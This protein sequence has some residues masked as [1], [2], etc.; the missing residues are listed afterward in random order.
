[1]MK[2]L[3]LVAVSF[4]C[5]TLVSQTVFEKKIKWSEGVKEKA[6][7]VTFFPEFVGLYQG[8]MVTVASSSLGRV[9]VKE[10]EGESLA[11][12]QRVK[13]NLK[14]EKNKL[15]KSDQLIFGDDLLIISNYR[16][17]STSKKHF[18]IQKYL[19]KGE[20][21][22]PK[23]I[24]TVHW[25]NVPG[26]F[27]SKKNSGLKYE[28]FNAV[29][30]IVSEDKKSLVVMYPDDVN[31]S[32]K[33]PVHW[34]V[35]AYD[36]D[37]NED[38]KYDFNIENGNIYLDKV[39]LSNDGILYCAGVENTIA[40][41]YNYAYIHLQQGNILGESYHLLIADPH[42]K[43]TKLVD[44]GIKDSTIIAYS[45]GLS[46]KN[47][48]FYGL[49]G[50]GRNRSISDGMFIKKLNSEGEELFYTV[51]KF[52]DKLTS[53]NED[54]NPKTKGVGRGLERKN[55]TQRN[56]ILDDIRFT[57]SG[58]MVF[59]AEQFNLYF[60]EQYMAGTNGGASESVSI[61]NYVYGD[62]I[63]ISCA[64]TGEIKWMNRI[65]KYQHTT[66]DLGF[67]SSY[68]VRV[69]GQNVHLLMNDSEFYVNYSGLKDAEGSVKR[70]A[71]KNEVLSAV[72]INAA[73]DVDRVIHIQTEDKKNYYKCAPKTLNEIS[74]GVMLIAGMRV[75]KKGL[76]RTDNFQ[77]V[78]ELRLK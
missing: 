73:G 49:T 60:T 32:K 64:P 28:A 4:V 31:P 54:I 71:K 53:Y 16:N 18:F 1:M 11:S 70:K 7:K 27:A 48:V 14:Y 29:K 68:H 78:G 17:K 62:I 57:E 21:S 33:E 13:L 15:V 56:F 42:N 65:V 36:E 39:K 69:K 24:A 9:F 35:V 63:A 50:S 46:G 44:L 22:K 76:L 40:L 41:T 45:M 61:P 75:E 37:L 72:T 6:L 10:Y 58:D 66:S 26:V 3:I 34:N 77:V 59:L 38:W 25:E 19:G 47:P 51:Q 23:L 8:K 52:S 67:Y 12:S 2:L 30:I 43:T 5:Q 55:K 20:L 74:N